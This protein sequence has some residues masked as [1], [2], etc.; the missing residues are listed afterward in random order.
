MIRPVAALQL[1]QEHGD[2]GMFMLMFVCVCVCVRAR[3]C[4]CGLVTGCQDVLFSA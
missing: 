3:V 4:V 2:G 1:V